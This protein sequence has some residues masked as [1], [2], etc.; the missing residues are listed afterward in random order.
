MYSRNIRFRLSFPFWRKKL[1]K[2]TTTVS[3][4]VL[5]IFFIGLTG[6]FGISTDQVGDFCVV[7]FSSLSASHSFSFSFSFSLVLSVFSS[8][9]SLSLSRENYFSL[10]PWFSSLSVHLSNFLCDFFLSSFP[11]GR[12]TSKCLSSPIC[13]WSR[14]SEM[15]NFR[16]VSSRTLIRSYPKVATVCILL[17]FAISIIQAYLLRD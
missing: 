5:Y 9:S 3:C 4:Y 14:S 16:I 12:P 15:R 11:V 6:I 7:T 13:P 8:A 17:L 2:I 10:F 1:A